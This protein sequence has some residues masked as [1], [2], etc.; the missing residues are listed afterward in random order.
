LFALRDAPAGLI[1]K[2]G[3]SLSKVYGAIGRFSEDIDLSLDRTDLG[4]REARDPAQAPSG[5]KAQKLLDEL[6]AACKAVIHEQL[7]PLL[8]VDFE[9]VLGPPGSSW[10]LT[11]DPD[12]EDGQVL[13]FNYPVGVPSGRE[14][15]SYLRPAVRLELGARSDRW[16]AEDHLIKPYAAEVLPA[17]FREAQCRVHVL[18]GERTFW[19]KAT[20]LHAEYHRPADKTTGE[21]VSRHYYDLARLYDGPIGK[22]ALSRLDLL[23]AVV[24]HKQ[25]FFRSARARYEEAQPGTLRL[26]PHKDR[27]EALERDY[28]AMAVMMFESPPPW[29]QVLERLRALEE[30]INRRPE[31]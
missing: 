12:A 20:S 17:A 27:S 25:L 1:F 10:S 16:P 5:K 9:T 26:V 31:S 23:E 4:F 28:R 14:V 15:P 22:R 24:K 7:L 19:E 30:D 18:A 6:A 21:R 2:G 3:T 8:R 11:A 13:N 29:A